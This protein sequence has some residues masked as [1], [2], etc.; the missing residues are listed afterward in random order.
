[1]MKLLLV[2]DQ[3]IVVDGISRLLSKSA[4]E[5]V[6]QAKSIDDALDYFDESEFDIL[7]TEY[8]LIDANCLHLLRKIKSIYPNS[9]II[10]LSMQDEV[11]LI[12]IITGD[13]TKQDLV[14]VI[15]DDGG[16]K[17]QLSK[18]ISDI[19]YHA[20]HDKKKPK[21]LSGKEK[22]V[23]NLIAR[24]Y[25]HQEIAKKLA[26]NE[27]AVESCCKNLYKKTKTSS[28]EGLLIYAFANNLV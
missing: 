24:E 27:K 22:N 17:I 19:I 9:K 28:T 13:N 20:K 14:E 4:K 1:M 15:S 6:K 26:L 10:V 21:L 18:Q 23:L 12:E 25:S 8:N 3:S 5:L 16:G 11:R 2:D 7:V